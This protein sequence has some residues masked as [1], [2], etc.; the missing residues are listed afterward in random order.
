VNA[1]DLVLIPSGLDMKIA[2]AL[3]VQGM[4][5]HYLVYSTYQVKKGDTVLVHAGAG[6]TGRLIIALA[7]HIGA[8]V[9]TTV[10]SA[11]K[12]KIAKDA[13]A[14]EV[15]NYTEC[16][17][18]EE[19]ARITQGKGVDVAYDSVGKSTWEGSLAS[20][21][22]RGMLV[23]F[24]NA[25]GPVPPIDPLR[26]SRGGSVYVTRPTLADYTLTREELEWRMSDLIKAYSAGYLPVNVCAEY[27]LKDAAS[28]HNL[29]ESRGTTGKI[30]LTP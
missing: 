8:R 6:G 14:H 9:I 27:P 21:K 10:S 23:L 16:K 29:L 12:A 30:I 15:I 7:N 24:G 26:L 11:E 19:V 1:A 22:K 2:A 4:T 5:A 17:F 25:S 28:A 13:G 20:L 18:E 3:P